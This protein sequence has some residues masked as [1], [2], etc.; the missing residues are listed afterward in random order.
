[1][2]TPSNVS[3]NA[4]EMT[5]FLLMMLKIVWLSE[6]T[7]SAVVKGAAGPEV[8]AMMAIWGMYVKRNMT[9]GERIRESLA[10]AL[11]FIGM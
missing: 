10:M 2:L 5:K 1:M 4:S 3:I 6:S 9:A 11:R 8:N 7:R